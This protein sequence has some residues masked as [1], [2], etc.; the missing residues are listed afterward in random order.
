MVNLLVGRII[1]SLVG[2]VCH[3]L[4][5][6][7]RLEVTLKIGS[8]LNDVS[9]YEEWT[10]NGAFIFEASGYISNSSEYEQMILW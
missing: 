9:D 7:L 8:E 3:V 6:W 2:V 5:V 1:V 4:L 10:S